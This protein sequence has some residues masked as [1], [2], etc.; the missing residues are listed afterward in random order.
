MYQK[1]RKLIIITHT[2]LEICKKL[3][4]SAHLRLHINQNLPFLFTNSSLQ[5]DSDPG[6]A[7]G[8]EILDLHFVDP[9]P[10]HWFIDRPYLFSSAPLPAILSRVPAGYT[11][12]FHQAVSSRQ[13]NQI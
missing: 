9:G 2:I 8:S 11:V 13:Y 1:S 5:K 6:Y 12:P 7:F 4:I 3:K 10:E